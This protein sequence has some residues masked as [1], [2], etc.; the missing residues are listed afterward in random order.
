MNTCKVVKTSQIL[1]KIFDLK[2][3]FFKIALFNR[4]VLLYCCRIVC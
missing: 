2:S 1:K 4:R 3:V